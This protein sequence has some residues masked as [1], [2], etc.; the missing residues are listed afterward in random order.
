MTAF[1]QAGVKSLVAVDINLDGAKQTADSVEGIA[2]E[3]NVGKED[4][5]ID[6]IPDVEL[7]VNGVGE[8]DEVELHTQDDYSIC[9]KLI[10]KEE[11]YNLEFDD[12]GL[13][14]NLFIIWTDGNYGYEIVYQNSPPAFNGEWH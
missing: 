5:I 10:I 2:V 9:N 3:A 8:L 7:L 11:T 13:E 1:Y 4:A 6:G 12:S 14:S